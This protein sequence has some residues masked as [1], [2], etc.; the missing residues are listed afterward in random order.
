MIILVYK[1]IWEGLAIQG[2]YFA[3]ISNC[4]MYPC[5]YYNTSKRPSNG[6]A[7]LH[8]NVNNPS[9]LNNV[10]LYT[11][12]LLNHED[13]VDKSICGCLREAIYCIP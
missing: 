6:V 13:L 8:M 4:K 2:E 10:I 9:S 7:G 3:C 12:P 5:E 1:V 11:L